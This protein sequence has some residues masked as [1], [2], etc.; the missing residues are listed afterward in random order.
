MKTLEAVL[1]SNI[2]KS[3]DK[4]SAKYWTRTAR[5]IH[6]HSEVQRIFTPSFYKKTTYN[7]FSNNQ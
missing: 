7:G 4:I 2:L 6:N 3:R 5:I 1:V